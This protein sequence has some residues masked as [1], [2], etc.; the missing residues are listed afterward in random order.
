MQGL[1]IVQ[2]HNKDINGSHSVNSISKSDQHHQQ[3]KEAPKKMTWASIASQP[4]KPQVNTTSTIV[5][6]KGPGMPPPPM[7]PGKHNMDI[8]TWDSPKNVPTPP[9]PV[10]SIP[11][12]PTSLTVAKQQMPPPPEP[13]QQFPTPN[14]GGPPMSGSQNATPAWPTPGQ[15]KNQQ[16]HQAS[17]I[18]V[19]NNMMPP[20]HSGGGMYS[21]DG[22]YKFLYRQTI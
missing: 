17:S 10:I 1:N 19:G 11:P 9:P 18:P 21:F 15:S 20:Q 3:Q 16:P 2:Q 12:T 4:A 8:G 13:N 22:F 5:K 7:V 6:K 14:L